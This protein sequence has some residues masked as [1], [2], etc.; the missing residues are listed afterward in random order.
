[1]SVGGSVHSL[2]AKLTALVITLLAVS[3]L[4]LAFIGI[5]HERDALTNEIWKRGITLTANLA[6]AAMDPLLVIEQ[7]DM[8]NE[9][10]LERLISEV[11]EPEGVSGARLLNREGRVVAAAASAERN[12][13]VRQRTGIDPAEQGEPVCSQRGSLFECAAPVIYDGLRIGEAQIEFDLRVLVDPVIRDNRNQ[14]AAAALALLAICGAT[15]AVFVAL[16]V[17]RKPE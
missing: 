3:C 5:R 15:G 4:S 6:R 9:L 10:A 16:L 13:K 14:L 11:G 8:V 2:Q 12:S 7:G 1:L 17:N